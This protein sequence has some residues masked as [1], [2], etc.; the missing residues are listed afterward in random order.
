MVRI[1]GNHIGR[2][3]DQKSRMGHSKGDVWENY[4]MTYSETIL[5]KCDHIGYQYVHFSLPV[6]ASFDNSMCIRCQDMET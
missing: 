1:G 5:E 3:L 6:Y 2:Y 4:Y